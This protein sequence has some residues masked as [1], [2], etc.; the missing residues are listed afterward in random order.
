MNK[1][2]SKQSRINRTLNQIKKDLVE[3][4][5][6][7]RCCHSALGTDLAHLLPR[8]TFPEYQTKKWNLALLCRNCHTKF[9]S[10]KEFRESTKLGLHI[11]Q[12]DILAYNR[13]YG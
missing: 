4:S 11:K 3:E 2:S 5:R 1:I 8:S 7:C 13:Y 10:N 6:V 9:D 12:I